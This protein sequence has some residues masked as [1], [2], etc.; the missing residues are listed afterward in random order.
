[1]YCGLSEQYGDAFSFNLS[2]EFLLLFA[3][4]TA[5]GDIFMQQPKILVFTD[6]LKKFPHFFWYLP[7][8]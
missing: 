8:C 5:R 1:M 6:W 2:Q 3:G 4:L 7:Y